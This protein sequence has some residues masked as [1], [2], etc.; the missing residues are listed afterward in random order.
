M[1]SRYLLLVQY[2]NPVFS[3][4][5]SFPLSRPVFRTGMQRYALFS[6]FQN[7]FQKISRK[8]ENSKNSRASLF[9]NSCP[10]RHPFFKWECKGTTFFLTSKL[11]RN[12]FCKILHHT[13]SKYAQ[14]LEHHRTTGKKKIT[15]K[16]ENSE[17]CDLNRKSLNLSDCKYTEQ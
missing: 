11:F 3:M 16:F 2:I 9:K 10:Y 6:N 15:R 7:F 17:Y 13:S 5:F 1:F 14:L 12:Y 8:L 4:N